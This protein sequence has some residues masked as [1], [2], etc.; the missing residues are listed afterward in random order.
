MLNVQSKHSGLWGKMKITDYSVTLPF[1]EPVNIKT[2]GQI[3]DGN[4]KVDISSPTEITAALAA[5]KEE[6][7]YD[8]PSERK[9]VEYPRLKYPEY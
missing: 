3:P 5:A 4:P 6:Y 2:R 1:P 9:G 7:I 8:A